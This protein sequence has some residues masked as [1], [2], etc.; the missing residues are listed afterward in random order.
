MSSELAIGTRCLY[1]DARSGEQVSATVI[2]V[3]YDDI[4][5]YYTIRIDGRE[6]E[7]E[8]IRSKLTVRD[9]AA[10][11]SGGTANVAG[12]AGLLGDLT[13]L[14]GNIA[15]GAARLF[16][17]I[18]ADND[19]AITRRELAAYLRARGHTDE[20]SERAFIEM[21]KDGDGLIDY[22]GA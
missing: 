16:R 14:D 11:I 9:E 19:G 8:T 17:D 18:D 3:H 20:V 22:E 15:D 1:A 5:A 10:D 21:D 6:G 4:P 7:R 2:K 12:L 13:M